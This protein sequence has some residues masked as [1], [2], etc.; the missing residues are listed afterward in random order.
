MNY[1]GDNE[2]C[3]CHGHNYYGDNE[4]DRTIDNLL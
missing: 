3:T 2:R 1:Y 4:R